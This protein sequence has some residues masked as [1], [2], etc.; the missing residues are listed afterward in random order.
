MTEREMFEKSLE[1]PSNFRKLSSEEQWDIDKRLG[2]LD[3][4][5]EGLTDEDWKRIK[6]HYE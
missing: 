2:I 4:Q 5:G 6:E 3:W 1:R